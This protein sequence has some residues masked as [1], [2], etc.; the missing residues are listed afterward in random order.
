M[1]RA[2]NL[3]ILQKPVRG[4]VSVDFE[5]FLTRLHLDKL[6]GRF[7]VTKFAISQYLG[8]LELRHPMDSGR[9][10]VLQALG[11]NVVM[12]SDAT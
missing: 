7:I 8:H 3:R 5:N 1:I 10:Q 2:S 4:W 6:N 9:I 12:Y 11:V